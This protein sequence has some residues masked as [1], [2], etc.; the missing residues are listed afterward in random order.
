MPLQN[1]ENAF[2]NAEESLQIQC[3]GALLLQIQVP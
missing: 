1:D 3:E 2:I